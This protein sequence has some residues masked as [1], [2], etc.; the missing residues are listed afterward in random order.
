[1]FRQLLCL[2]MRSEHKKN[3]NIREQVSGIPVWYNGI[4]HT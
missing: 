1:M 2:F 4:V 3:R